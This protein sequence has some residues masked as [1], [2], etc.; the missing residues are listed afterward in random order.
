M[1]RERAQRLARQGEARCRLAA[2]RR[3]LCLRLRGR[4]D[5]VCDFE[6]DHRGFSRRP[7]ESLA[8]FLLRLADSRSLAGR[9]NPPCS[10]TLQGAHAGN[11]ICAICAICKTYRGTCCYSHIAVR[12]EKNWL[13]GHHY[14][15]L[16][17]NMALLPHAVCIGRKRFDRPPIP[18]ARFRAED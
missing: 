5:R 13:S 6:L 3:V 1:R 4:E 16:R 12:T 15:G 11:A 17:M 8:T 10:L 14:P 9:Y 7:R 2:H 18:L